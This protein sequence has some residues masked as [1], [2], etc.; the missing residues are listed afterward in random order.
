MNA[1]KPIPSIPSADSNGSNQSEKTDIT[2]YKQDFIFNDDNMSNSDKKV[3]KIKLHPR[4]HSLEQK[5]RKSEEKLYDRASLNY[6][7]YAPP[8]IP[9][10]MKKYS[11]V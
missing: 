4:N 8:N 9:R 5:M 10:L 1:L 3:V 6:K 11:V 2:D 7:L